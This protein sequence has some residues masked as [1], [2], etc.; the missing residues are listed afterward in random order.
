MD[1]KLAKF[2]HIALWLQMLIV[3]CLI[4]LCVSD[5]YK[6]LQTMDDVDAWIAYAQIDVAKEDCKTAA[7]PCKID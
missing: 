5:H 3:C 7:S 2:H 4:G 1:T 6:L